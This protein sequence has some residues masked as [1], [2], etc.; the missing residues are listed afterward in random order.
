MSSPFDGL[1]SNYELRDADYEKSKEEKIQ[2][3]HLL[4]L[5]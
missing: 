5:L 3:T 1:S 4:Y 2:S